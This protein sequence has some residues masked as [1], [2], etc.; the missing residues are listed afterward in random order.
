MNN[1][2]FEEFVKVRYSEMDY[3]LTLKPVSLLHFLQDLASDNAEALGFGYSFITQR[4]LGW[5]LLK[6]RM[7]FEDYPENVY[8]LKIT[9][10]PRGYNKLFAYRD[11]GIYN[12]EK[13]L[14]RAT[15]TWSLVD[16]NS[17]RLASVQNILQDNSHMVQFEKRENDLNYEKISPLGK[18]DI[19]KVFEIRFDDIDVNKHVNN[20]NYITWALEPL[21]FSFKTNK[22]LK[23]LDVIFK[24]ELKFGSK[25][26]VQV[27]FSENQTTHLLK[28]LETG[29]DLCTV[30]AKWADKQPICTKT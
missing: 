3:T 22:K 20:A 27:G 12:D 2:V 24:K 30:C 4:N 5:F 13:L 18:I 1:N 14:G 28:C 29:E 25:V 6:Y 23:T 11:F 26:L 21:P 9:T 7:E 8:D 19:E 10:E 15:S 16:I 17:K